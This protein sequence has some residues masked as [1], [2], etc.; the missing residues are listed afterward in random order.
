MEMI[1]K[2]WIPSNQLNEVFKGNMPDKFW[3]SE[4]AHS[5]QSVS[6]IQLPFSVVKSWQEAPTSNSNKKMLLD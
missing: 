5:T 6:E 2:V 4:P 3:M 1:V